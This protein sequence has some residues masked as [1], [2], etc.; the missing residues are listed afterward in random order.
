LE[1]TPPQVKAETQSVEAPSPKTEVLVFKQTKSEEAARAA[2]PSPEPGKIEEELFTKKKPVAATKPPQE[3]VLKI[4]DREEA[5]SQ[6]QGLVRQFGGETLATKAN[7]LLASL[8]KDSFP[9]FEKEL[10]GVSSTSKTDKGIMREQNTEGLR[11]L[12]RMKKEAVEGKSGELARPVTDEENR[13][14]VRILLIQE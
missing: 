14:V 11:A 9:E 8:P 13:I 2:A 1:P 5:I 3:I 4:S 12:D 10:E 7:E 6:V